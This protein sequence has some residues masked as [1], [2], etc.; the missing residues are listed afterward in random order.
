M[1]SAGTATIAGDFGAFYS[2]YILDPQDAD[3]L[4][5]GTCRV[6][7]GSTAGTG[8]SALSPNF[9]TGASASCT[10]N[11]INQVRSIAAG[12][13]KD[14]S[15]FSNVV[16]A[17]SDGNGPNA[18]SGG[19]E[20]WVTTNAATTLMSNVTGSINPQGYTISSV[21]IDSS[22]GTGQTAYVGIMGFLGT[23]SPHVWK[24][25]N[26]GQTWSAFGNVGSGLPDAPVN[27]LL[28]DPGSGLIYAGTDVG[29]FASPMGA[30]TWSEVGPAPS[31][32]TSGYL[33]NAPVSALRMFTSGGTKKLRVSTYGRGLWEYALTAGP[34]F[35][36]VVAN[37]S[38]TVFAAQA[39]TF[40]AA[41]TAK[42]GYSSPVNLSCG[43]SP[44]STCTPSAAQVTPTSGGAAYSVS[45]TG[46]VGD[47]SFTANAVG[48]DVNAVT[49]DA[50]LTLHVVN[51]AVGA[52][53]PNP[54]S[55][56]QGTSGTATFQVSASGSFG[57]AVALSC[58]GLPSGGS[59]SFSPSSTVSPT[60]GNPVTVTVTVGTT[61]GTP[62]A[63]STVTI[64]GATSGPAAT[65]TAAFT[66]S[67]TAPP[68]FSWTTSGATAHTVR[69]GQTTLI[70][71]FSAAPTGGST[72]GSPVTFSC[73]G[74]PD[75]TAACV[76]SPA[77]IASGAG[78]TPVSVT[79]TTKG[80]NTDSGAAV[81]RHA[82][83]RS[84]LLP[85]TLP[86]VSGVVFS[87]MR[88]KRSRHAIAIALCT[89][90]AIAGLLV[91]CQSV[92]S[93]APPPPG[94]TITP[95]SANVPLGGT[96][97]FSASEAVTWSVSGSGSLGTIDGN[98]MYTAPSSGSTPAN[99]T[100]K[101]ISSADTTRSTTAQVAIPAVSVNVSPT[102]VNLYP[103]VAGA[104]GWPPQTQQLTAMVNNAGNTAVNWTVSGGGSVDTSG[105]YTAPAT[106][107]NPA[108]V[109][110]TATSQ[111]DA[112]KS[113]S[114]AVNILTPTTLG[115]FTVTVTA[116]EGGVSHA[117]AVTL[118]VQ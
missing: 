35:T 7:R 89:T 48:T 43:G 54:L 58:S 104:N 18:G 84:P 115:T 1:V 36:N 64:Q 6:W 49:H 108:T 79:I 100:I 68:N 67:V 85:W 24:T 5:V 117:Q 106:V 26:A 31:S 3:E 82:E 15:G 16:Y 92:S 113:G 95:A 66:L 41:L 22:D 88:R 14:N 93:N 81:Q 25:T 8:F 4:L 99:A 56:A 111:A 98:G 46:A 70:Y 32:G 38:Q 21:A 37:P 103:N 71:T 10:G 110:V 80:P 59:C 97:Q 61:A 34:D 94:L 33:P 91:G 51:F 74:L 47:Y 101:A 12:G 72:F 65:R 102:P 63:S 90:L 69:A 55:V 83:K 20:V 50:S 107:P 75:A 17:T 86:L 73:S 53:A 78:T 42:N 30:A 118:T 45:A 29:V 40:N 19:G 76:F 116:T 13:P 9:E 52:V 23:T 87:L 57:L 28:V 96:R 77:S 11:E 112:A 109:Q 105:L 39:A 114:A 27:S 60:A 62:L 44:P 2:P